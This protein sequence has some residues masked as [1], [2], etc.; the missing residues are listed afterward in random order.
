MGEAQKRFSHFVYTI[1]F[2]TFV[3]QTYLKRNYYDTIRIQNVPQA[4]M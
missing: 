1:F 3:T 2:I 4:W